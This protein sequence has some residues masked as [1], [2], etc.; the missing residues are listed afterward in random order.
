MHPCT[1]N[2]YLESEV[3]YGIPNANLD[4]LCNSLDLDKTSYISVLLLFS[5]CSNGIKSNKRLEGSWVVDYGQ[6]VQT[7]MLWITTYVV[8]EG[9]YWSAVKKVLRQILSIIP[10]GTKYLIF[11]VHTDAIVSLKIGLH[12]TLFAP[13]LR[14]FLEAQPTFRGLKPLHDL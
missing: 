3:L 9:R 1:V 7:P 4:V 6:S 8:V 2:K 13:I 5:V 10:S 12:K 14:I 11:I